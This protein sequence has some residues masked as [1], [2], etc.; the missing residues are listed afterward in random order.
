MAA[1]WETKSLDEM[2]A[3]EWESLCDGCG[4]C[5]LV[6]LEDEDTGRIHFTNVAC[7]YLDVETCQCKDYVNRFKSQPDCTLLTKADIPAFHWLPSSCAYRLLS[8]DKPL[9]KWHHLISGSKQQVLQQKWAINGK[10]VNN[11][12]FDDERLQAHIVRWI[13]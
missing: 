2:S 3:D 6:K 8:E 4:K 10:I 13:D 9:P 7:E 12:D 5:C 11:A 1:F